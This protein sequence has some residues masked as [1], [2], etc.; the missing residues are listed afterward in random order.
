VANFRAPAAW[1]TRRAPGDG[2][3][4]SN[5]SRMSKN[6][7]IAWSKGPKGT[8]SYAIIASDPD[9]PTIR[10]DM[11]Q[12]GKTWPAGMPRRTFYHWLL[13]DIPAG[14]T[15]IEAP[16]PTARCRMAGK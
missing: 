5:A 8:Q 1:L 16:T 15:T 7:K 4:R 6:P 3:A 10:T 11:N 12:E 2:V 13:I 14:V 9:V